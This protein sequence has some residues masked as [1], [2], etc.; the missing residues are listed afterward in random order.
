M[1]AFTGPT[2]RSEIPSLRGVLVSSLAY[3]FSFRITNA[4][5]LARCQGFFASLGFPL[6]EHINHTTGFGE[7]QGKR[8][9]QIAQDSTKLKIV[10]QRAHYLQFNSLDISL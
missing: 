4:S 10:T 2:G 7:S 3:L 9:F 8:Q 1:P 5:P 6:W